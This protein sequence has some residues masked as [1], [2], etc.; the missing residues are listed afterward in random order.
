MF[1]HQKRKLWLID[2]ADS[3]MQSA[4]PIPN[5]ELKNKL[6]DPKFR[7]AFVKMI[8]AEGKDPGPVL[9]AVLGDMSAYQERQDREL[10]RKIEAEKRRL[11]GV[12]A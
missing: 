10:G 1:R 4:V 3:E 5:S 9:K 8:K 12:T 2:N 6:Q 11:A 7:E